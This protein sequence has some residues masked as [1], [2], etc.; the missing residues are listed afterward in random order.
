MKKF[1]TFLSLVFV[2]ALVAAP[3]AVAKK[4][5]NVGAAQIKFGELVYDFGTITEK[6]GPVSHN[7]EFTNQGDANLAI[8]NA[9][10]ECGCTRPSYPTNPIAPGKG[11]VVKVTFNPAGRFG[12]FEKVVT[13]T[14]TGRPAKVRLK[15]KGYIKEK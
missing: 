5:K 4:N 10:A 8:L 3:S 7:F 9:T 2:V 12:S 14:A 11:G 6:G 15:I 1:L 13:V